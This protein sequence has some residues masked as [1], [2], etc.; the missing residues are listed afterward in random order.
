VV[1]SDGIKKG[2]K[3]PTQQSKKPTTRIN[4]QIR[5]SELRVVTAEG[6]NFG[7]LSRSEALEKA[8]EAGLDLIEIAPTAQ[9]PV[10]KIMDYGKFQYEQKKKQQKQK[11][12]SQETETKNIQVKIGTSQHDLELKSKRVTEW[13]DEGHRVKIDLFLKG[14]SK[15]M[16]FEFLKE[17]LERFMRL[18]SHEYTVADEIKKGPKGLTTT[19]EPNQ[20]KGKKGGEQQQ[21]AQAATNEQSNTGN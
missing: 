11:Q 17:R 12:K 9:P 1:L 15:Y 16:E 8:Q 20:K 21:D 19:I 10:A 7:V 3:K 5:S 13:L 18:I 6:D 2:R 4:D 14:R